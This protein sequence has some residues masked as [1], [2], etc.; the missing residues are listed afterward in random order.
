[1]VEFV[2]FGGKGGVG[3]TTVAS[4]YALKCARAGLDTLVVSTD[5]AHSTADVFDQEFGDDPRPVEGVENLRAMEID[6]ETEVQEHLQETKRALGEQLSSSMVGEIDLQIEMAHRTPG[7]YEAALLDRFIDVMRTAECDRVVF[8]TSPTGSTLRLL[9]LPDLLEK[10]IDRLAYKREK[11]IDYFEMAAVGKQEPRR[12]REGDP[13][14]ARL[15]GRKE[16]FAFA[17]E[18]LEEATFYLVCTPDD[19]SVRETERSLATHREYDLSVG[20]VVINKRTPE[21]DPDEEG[22]GA[23]FLRGKVETER[24]RIAEMHERFDA[25]I[26]G[27]I[28]TRIREI[29]GD[30]LEEV[31][32]ELAVDG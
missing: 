1:M 13:I 5:P 22:R 15:R 23:R 4:A 25:P 32:A 7:A 27:E 18:A 2:F 24:E 20:G 16:R 14:L 31:A 17:G 30:L 8:D 3:K 9:S 28:E 19:L 10:W 26:V 6:P 11:S 29:K 21:P 12:V